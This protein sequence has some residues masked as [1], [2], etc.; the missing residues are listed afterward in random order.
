M[1]DNSSDVER[2]SNS[3]KNLKTRQINS[4]KSYCNQS[5]TY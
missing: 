4:S 5:E 3:Y 2:F 1:L